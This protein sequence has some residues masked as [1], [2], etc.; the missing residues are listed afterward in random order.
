MVLVRHWTRFPGA[1][2]DAEGI[3]RFWLRDPI[4]G[5]LR[6]ERALATLAA[7]GLVEARASADGRTR[8]WRQPGPDNAQWLAWLRQQA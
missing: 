7:A 8:W 2:D 3:G 6:A 5:P 1:S 4:L